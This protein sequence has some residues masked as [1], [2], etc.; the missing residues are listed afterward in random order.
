VAYSG[1]GLAV[2]RGYCQGHGR[3]LRKKHP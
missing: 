2:A 3:A 1:A